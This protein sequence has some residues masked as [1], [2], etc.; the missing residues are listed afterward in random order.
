MFSSW[1]NY[2]FKSP[3]LFAAFACILSNLLYC[4]SYDHGG[5]ALLMISR[6]MTGLGEPLYGRNLNDNN[7]R[8]VLSKLR[9]RCMLTNNDLSFVVSVSKSCP[10]LLQMRDQH[11]F[12]TCHI[13]VHRKLH[14]VLSLRALSQKQ[15]LSAE[16]F[17]HEHARPCAGSSR[18]VSRRY[19]ADFTPRSKRTP[20]STGES[21][22]KGF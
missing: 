9:S 20:A 18:S 12:C 15:C 14:Q 8:N 16:F 6:F 3:M 1:S 21:G 11:C 5:L 10:E 22:C 2:S 13:P 19:I 4:A 17:L 7:D